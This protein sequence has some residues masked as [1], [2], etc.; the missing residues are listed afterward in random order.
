MLREQVLL[1]GRAFRLLKK[2]EPGHQARQLPGLE[3]AV[4][5]EALQAWAA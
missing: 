2:L 1:R 3:L 4:A 5:G